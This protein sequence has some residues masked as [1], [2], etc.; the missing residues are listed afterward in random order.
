MPK[1]YQYFCPECYEELS[2]N[3]E[4]VFD[5][6]RSNGDVLELYL[7]VTPNTYNYRSEPPVEFVFGEQVE[8]YCPHC[9]LSLESPRKDKFVVIDLK[10]DNKKII[11]VS[12]SKIFGEHKTFVGLKQFEEEYPS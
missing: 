9:T 11:E 7:D 10:V 4:I 3:G 1:T 12:F 8:F 2:S 5:V 6:C